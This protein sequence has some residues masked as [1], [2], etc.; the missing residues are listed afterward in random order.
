MSSLP[1][2]ARLAVVIAAVALVLGGGIYVLFLRG[3]DDEPVVEAGSRFGNEDQGGNGG[4]LLETLAPVL[5]ASQ[6]GR[7]RGSDPPPP[8]PDELERAPGD[9][10]AGLF[11][12]GFPGTAPTGSFFER[13]GDEEVGR[14]AARAEHGD[15]AVARLA[16]GHDALRSAPQALGVGDGGPSELH[17]DGAGHDG[18]GG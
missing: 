17:D 16:L 2:R 13:L 15:D 11:I 4:A 8:T 12:V 9:A 14:L 5:S 3:G 7:N 10:V 18:F 6:R 1:P